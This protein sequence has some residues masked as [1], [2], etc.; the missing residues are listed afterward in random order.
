M[1]QWTAP[2]QA[3]HRAVLVR[4]L[5]PVTVPVLSVLRK[6]QKLLAELRTHGKLY[7]LGVSDQYW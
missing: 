4:T 6:L 7:V 3:L 1:D 5:L 2:P